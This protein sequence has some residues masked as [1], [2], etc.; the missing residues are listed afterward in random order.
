[1]GEAPLPAELSAHFFDAFSTEYEA[2]FGGLHQ[3]VASRVV[4]LAA[5]R[6]GE[7]CLEVGCGTG[8]VANA[9]AEPVGPDGQ[10]V[11][12][13]VSA[14][15]L[16]LARSRSLPNTT[17]HHANADPHLPFRDATFDLAVFCDS[18]AYMSDPGRTLEEARRVLRAGGRILLALRWRALDTVAQEVFFRM[19]DRVTEDH[20][21]V[22][23]QERDSRGLLGEPAVISEVLRQARFVR[24][25]TTALVTG[26]RARSAA[27]WLD[28][29][30]RVGPRPYALIT[31]LVPR[32]RRR[33]E[34]QLERAMRRLGDEAFHHHEAYTFAGAVAG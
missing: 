14:G 30:S 1:M 22:I 4:E 21:V 9:L 20:P 32:Q 33:L 12:V 19:L 13:D 7:A 34:D 5:P 24:P 3:K 10:I 28:F 27:E 11:G 17:F 26:G 2:W 18:L 6:L 8:L 16:R 31:T 23:R 25:W 29:M 15:M